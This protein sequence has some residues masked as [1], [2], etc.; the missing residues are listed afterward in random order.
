MPGLAALLPLQ[1][2]MCLAYV[3]GNVICN[4]VDVHS[5]QER[6][7]HAT[8]LSLANM[9]PLYLSGGCEFGACIL[10]C[11]EKHMELFIA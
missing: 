7:T 5:L 2:L 4:L 3:A 1:L 10:E 8:H 9:W 11:L 6:A